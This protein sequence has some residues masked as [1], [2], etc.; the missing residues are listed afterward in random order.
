MARAGC[1]AAEQSLLGHGGATFGTAKAALHFALPGSRQ[2]PQPEVAV[3]APR[4]R[5]GPANRPGPRG[6]IAERTPLRTAPPRKAIRGFGRCDALAYEERN[7]AAIQ[8]ELR[9]YN[10]FTAA[11]SHRERDG[12]I[13]LPHTRWSVNPS[14]KIIRAPPAA[15]PTQNQLTCA[16]IMR[17]QSA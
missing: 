5:D 3:H 6:R 16:R 10:S 14:I 9:A 2:S 12:K 15:I 7:H 17:P 4:R 13:V 11:I 1:L 8:P